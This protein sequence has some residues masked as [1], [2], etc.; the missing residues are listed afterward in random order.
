MLTQFSRK[1][2]LPVAALAALSA[3]ALAAPAQAKTGDIVQ[4]AIKAGKFKTLVTALKAAGLVSALKGAGPFTVFAP[5][6]AAFA[7]L[8][9]GTVA[10]LL[11]PA[12]KAKLVKILT[13]HVIPG[14]AVSAAQAM[15]MKKPTSP[16]T[17]E[18]KAVNIRTAHGHV[19][20]NNATVVTPDIK[21]TNG[22]IHAID[23]VLMP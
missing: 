23:T 11:K 10:M 14:V 20:I 16:P 2:I 12:N 1:A 5:T 7:K 22:V 17:L 9:K 3:F 18:G 21:A 13:Y 15:A 4:T 6:D 8:P 19:T